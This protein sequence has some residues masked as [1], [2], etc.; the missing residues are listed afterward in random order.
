M[1]VTRELARYALDARAADMP[2]AVHHEAL[3]S[4]LNWV[5]CAVGGS[6]HEAVE[7]SLAALLRSEEHTSELQSR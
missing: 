5:G 1:S 4:I 3:R 2:D 7:R 6:R